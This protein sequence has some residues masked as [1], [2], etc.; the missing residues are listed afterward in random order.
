MRFPR[1]T[2][3]LEKDDLERGN[4]VTLQPFDNYF[5]SQLSPL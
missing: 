2:R 1:G 3:Y 5:E 4:F